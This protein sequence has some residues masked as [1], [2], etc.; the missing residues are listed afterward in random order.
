[1][2]GRRG[3]GWVRF[4]VKRLFSVGCWVRFSVFAFHFLCLSG[5]GVDFPL[6]GKIGFKRQNLI[7]FDFGPAGVRPATGLPPT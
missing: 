5:C 7:F 4:L 3:F 2:A 6:R 1:V